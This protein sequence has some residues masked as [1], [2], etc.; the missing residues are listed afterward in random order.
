M[1]ARR[2]LFFGTESYALPILRPLARVIERRGDDTAWFFSGPSATRLRSDEKRLETVAAVRAFAPAAVFVPGNWVPDFFPGSKI[3]VFHGF[4]VGKRRALRGHFRI[5]GYFDLYCTQGPATT[6]PFLRLAARHRHFRVVET[7]W[8]KM[9]PLFAEG[10]PALPAARPRPVVLY[11]STFSE[12]LTSTG[13]LFDEVG[14][15]AAS[16]RWDWIVTFHPKMPR[17]VVERYRSLEGPHLRLAETDDVLPLLR[18]A[19]VMLSDTSS[20]ASEF[21][22]LHKPVVTF[23]NRQPGSHLLDVVRQAQVTP[24][25]EA[26]LARPPEL[27]EAIRA[28][29]AAI[30]PYRDGR[31]SERV[32]AAAD[33]SV[34]RG[35][36]GLRR[37]PLNLWRKLRARQELRYYRVR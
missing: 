10:P 11:A 3:A 25:I 23:R 31:S 32:L 37:R 24:A 4:S 15:A 8:P 9:D 26:A 6:E 13:L 21:L 2:Y 18:Q 27:L 36:R 16:G 5:R 7:G 19:D 33:E 22:L 20:I 29:A 35:R 28:Y 30:H 12:S 34:E 17:A 14:R 1:T